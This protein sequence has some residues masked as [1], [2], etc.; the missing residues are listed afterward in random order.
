[1]AV[2]TAEENMAKLATYREI[3]K[4]FATR[5]PARREEAKKL[6]ARARRS[7]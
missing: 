4:K 7:S 6:A 5:E 3:V 2:I 1:M